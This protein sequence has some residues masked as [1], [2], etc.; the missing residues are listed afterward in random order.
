[1]KTLVQY[2]LEKQGIFNGCED[3]SNEL[4][5]EFV[6]ETKRMFSHKFSYEFDAIK[7]NPIFR[8]IILVNVIFEKRAEIEAESNFGN[9]EEYELEV[10]NAAVSG[11]LLYNIKEIK[12]LQRRELHINIKAP[13]NEINLYDLKGVFMHELTHLYAAIIFY[14]RGED[15]FGRKYFSPNDQKSRSEY[16]LYIIQS[17]EVN[18]LVTEFKPELDKIKRNGFDNVFNKLKDKKDFKQILDYID[19]FN[20]QDWFVDFEEIELSEYPELFRKHFECDYSD[21]KIYRIT[22]NKLNDAYNQLYKNIIKMIYEYR[23]SDDYILKN[24]EDEIFKP[25]KYLPIIKQ[26]KR[27]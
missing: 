6:K 3:I 13:I 10:A 15:Y 14:D 17:D 20:R 21:T 27:K 18:S 26:L 12:K 4:V 1:M 19:E 11:K 25:Y 23:G 24:F 5:Y 2:I 16:L 22:R 9:N 8:N 7:Y